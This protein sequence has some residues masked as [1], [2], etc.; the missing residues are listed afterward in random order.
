MSDRPVKYFLVLDNEVIVA[1]LDDDFLTDVA[2]LID[3]VMRKYPDAQ[4]MDASGYHADMPWEIDTVFV[5][6]CE[7][8]LDGVST[9]AYLWKEAPRPTPPVNYDV[10]DTAQAAYEKGHSD[11][12]K[13]W[14]TVILM[15]LE[16]TERKF[17]F[18]HSGF[19]K[20]MCSHIRC[21]M[22]KRYNERNI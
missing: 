13:D 21:Q 12:L 18:P 17:S 5:I 9:V 6:P 15:L 22:S 16:E 1:H 2:E 3:F 14:Q 4:A 8:A 7:S 10:L 11:G 19:G 20:T